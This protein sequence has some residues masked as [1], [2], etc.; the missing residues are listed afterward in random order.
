MIKLACFNFLG[1]KVY[2]PHVLKVLWWVN[3]IAPCGRERKGKN[4]KKNKK[5][6]YYLL[7]VDPSIIN[8]SMNE[9]RGSYFNFFPPRI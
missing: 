4:K 6:N 1:T 5:P 9:L 7:L 2:E 8:R 3:Q